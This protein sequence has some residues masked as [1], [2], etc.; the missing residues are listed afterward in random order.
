MKFLS[1][2]NQHFGL[3]A[4]RPGQ[5][6]AV[7]AVVN[8]SNDVLVFCATGSGKSLCYQLP[9]LMLKKT[10]V[11]VSPLISLMQDQVIK[12]NNTF[13]DG[14]PVACFLGS[15]QRDKEVE[16]RALSGQYTF[17]YV[18]P[19]KIASEFFLQQLSGIQNS[20]GLFAVDEAHC[21]C[22]YGIDFRKD[23]STLSTFRDHFPTIP[24]MALT[25]TAGPDQRIEIAENLK[26]K[27]PL[28]IEGSLDR[29]NLKIHIRNR[30][31]PRK[32]LLAPLVEMINNQPTGSTGSTIIY[33]RTRKEAEA[34]AE[35]FSEECPNVG[36]A[37]YHGGMSSK[38]RHAI[39][40]DFLSGKTTLVVATIAFGMG[41]DKPDIRCVVHYGPPKTLGEYYQQIGRAGRDGKDAICM[42]FCAPGDFISYKSDFYMG[43]MNP[44]QRQDM[45]DK[46]DEFRTFAINKIECRRHLILQHFKE[47]IT[48]PPCGVCDN[49][50]SVTKFE[51][52]PER[53]YEP[54]SKI[55]LSAVS[56]TGERKLGISSLLEI[57]AG[58][59][60]PKTSDDSEKIAEMMSE[61][62]ILK[63][64]LK[65]KSKV[66][67]KPFFSTLVEK[68]YLL[69][70]AVT[71]PG[72]FR[73][74]EGYELTEKGSEFLQNG[75]PVLLPIPKIKPRKINYFS[76]GGIHRNNAGISRYGTRGNDLKYRTESSIYGPYI[77][78]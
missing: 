17:V 73:A 57:I 15:A 37:A 69:A 65:V 28:L 19:E 43:G 6:E 68:G 9:G 67:F 29:T 78:K 64:P 7:Q 72:I 39:H 27:K 63:K 54:E 11:V 61:I 22:E 75:G 76:T 60:Q 20:I 26:M 46:I 74:Y 44:I 58:K 25:A 4:F 1:A 31:S 55:I 62:Q 47:K 34:I 49:C 70:N 13:G 40:V 48:T 3:K 53:D 38:K 2:L 14:K 35:F 21:I 71:I 5:K 24:I 45:E 52:V 77:E 50:T 56:A 16:E 66:H 59:Y 36:I 10:V 42:M 8:S 32:E 51:T 41:I 12:L 18:T 33:A 30:E 23:Y